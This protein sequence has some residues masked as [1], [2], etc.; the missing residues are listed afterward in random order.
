MSFPPISTNGVKRGTQTQ[1]VGVGLERNIQTQRQGDFVDFLTQKHHQS[2][3][4]G[5]AYCAVFTSDVWFIAKRTL[6]CWLNDH[7]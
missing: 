4:V 7:R 1:K 6:A 5:G 3:L 2:V